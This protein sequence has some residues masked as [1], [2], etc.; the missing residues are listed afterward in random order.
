M[1]T[2]KKYTVEL[3]R[4]EVMAVIRH[5]LSSARR[6]VKILGAASLKIQAASPLSQGRRLAELNREASEV[7]NR[8]TSRAKGL[9]SI[10]TE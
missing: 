9:A 10:I 6:V 8:H 7:M 1:N 2:E 3:S 4:D 5:H